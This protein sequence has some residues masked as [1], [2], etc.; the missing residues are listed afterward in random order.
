MVKNVNV[1]EAKMFHDVH[2]NNVESGIVSH[3]TISS[4]FSLYVSSLSC[5]E[6][7]PATNC[8]SSSCASSRLVLSK[9]QVVHALF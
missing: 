1:L 8:Y 4:S 7:G 3:V 6:K 5:K 2:Q 9:D